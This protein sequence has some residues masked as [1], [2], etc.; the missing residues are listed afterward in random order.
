MAMVG[1]VTW[2]DT[3]RKMRTV[4]CLAV[5]VASTSAGATPRTGLSSM[6]V[7]GSVIDTSARWS[8]D[9]SRIVTTSVVRTAA[10][11]VS[12][13]Q[14]GGHVDG[15]TMRTFPAPEL[16]AV[17]MRV[18]IGAHPALDLGKR[19]HIAVDSVKVLALP[20]GFVRTGPTERGNFL[21]WESGCVI[22]TPDAAGTNE[23]VGDTEFVAISAS[24]NEWNTE[25]AGCSFMHLVEADR[26]TSEV[27]RDSRNLIKFRD[28]SWCRPAIDDDPARC[29][30]PQAA[31][32]TTAVFV[33][34]SDSDRDG[35]IVD[36]DVEL[37]GVDFAISNDG[38][39]TGTADCA[40][41]IKNTLTHELGHMLG[42]EHPCLADSDPPRVDGAGQPVPSCFGALSPA[43][44]EATMYNFQDCGETKKA[45]LEADDI[46]AICSTY[47]ASDDPG[48]CGPVG[49]K[50]GC[51]SAS[52]DSGVPPALVP[53]ALLML[54]VLLRRKT[55]TAA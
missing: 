21:F 45:S 3:F 6:T 25:V 7:E 4:A 30:S 5:L 53:L 41:D 19:T 28:T 33:D 22:A 40:A 18:A 11:D 48:Q 42:L 37:N 26:V 8:A 52:S 9:G 34:D 51:C 47:P 36:A 16:L 29:Y 2:R 1:L 38:Q 31:G 35:A 46:Q 24:I 20:A 14:L 32:L 27:G 55:S 12:V 54:I 15:L 17:G 23:V 10:G 43:I 13:S 50:A 44:T 49:E 39:T